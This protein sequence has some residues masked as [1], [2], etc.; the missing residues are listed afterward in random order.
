MGSPGNGPLNVC[1]RVCVRV[2]SRWSRAPVGR[3]RRRLGRRAG[4]AYAGRTLV[5][6]RPDAVGTLQASAS[7]S[8]STTAHSPSSSRPRRSGAAAERDRD[9][10][11]LHRRHHRPGGDNSPLNSVTVM[12]R[13]LTTAITHTHTHLFNGPFSGTTRVSRYQK[14]KTNL[15][16]TEARDSEWQWQQRQSTEG[17]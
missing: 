4:V 11:R 3:G 9:R 6:A 15:D 17:L 16:F 14:G 13:G 12:K 5:A 2:L 7:A 1:V 8:D 10:D